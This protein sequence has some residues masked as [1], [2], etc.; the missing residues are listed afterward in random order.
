LWSAPRYQVV[1]LVRRQGLFRLRVR[2]RRAR[3]DSHPLA[4]GRV[5]W[6]CNAFPVADI[7]AGQEAAPSAG[8]RL[9]PASAGPGGVPSSFQRRAG[10]RQ[11]CWP[12]GTGRARSC[13]GRP[14][15]VRVGHLAQPQQPTQASPDVARVAAAVRRSTAE[16]VHPDCGDTRPAACFRR[17]PTCPGRRGTRTPSGP[18]GRAR[19]ID[20]STRLDVCFSTLQ[21]DDQI[22]D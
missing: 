3:L 10:G 15:S 16:T 14:A 21:S 7:A 8:E 12:A 1:G 20:A 5:P 2:A 17:W 19:R 22:L 18:S 11:K 6:D 13:R 9:R 4:A